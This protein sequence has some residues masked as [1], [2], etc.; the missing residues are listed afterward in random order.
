MSSGDCVNVYTSC[1]L[2]LTYLWWCREETLR[3]LRLTLRSKHINITTTTCY[4]LISCLDEDVTPDVKIV[5]LIPM[6]TELT[7]S[8]ALSTFLQGNF[9]L[10]MQDLSTSSRTE[11]SMLFSYFFFFFFGP[12]IKSINILDLSLAMVGPNCLCPTLCFGGIWSP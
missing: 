1:C 12:T 5:G 3:C 2:Y 7:T 8:L 10:V 6:L 11:E 4:C 9:L